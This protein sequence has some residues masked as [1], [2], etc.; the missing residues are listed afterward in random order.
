MEEKLKQIKLLLL[1]VDGVLTDGRIFYIEDNL[2]GKAFNVK[3]GLGIKML[4]SKGVEV[5]IVTGR[6]SKALL[7]RCKD[8][9][10]TLIFDGVE[11]KADV[12]PQLLDK[13]GVSAEEIA[14]IGDDI[15]DV[16][17][18]KKIGVPIAVKD[19]AEKVFDY[20]DIITRKQ[21]GFGAVREICD[22]IL[23]A[24]GYTNLEE[25]GAQN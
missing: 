9:G 7:R 8:L 3:D 18:L 11:N 4:L 19:A 6:T 17:L 1:D 10:I 12:L 13:T 5:G 21:G 20:V 22:R 2:E 16:T 15:A 14:F 24:Q 23:E 25:V